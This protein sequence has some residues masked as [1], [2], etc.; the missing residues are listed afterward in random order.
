MESELFGH[1]RGAFTGAA[2]DRK[3]L[4]EEANGG[5]LFMDEI[6][7]LPVRHAVE[8]AEGLE[9]REVRPVGSNQTRKIDVR[10]I[11]ASSSSLRKLVAEK[12]FREDL[13]YRLNVYPIDV[14]S[15]EERVEDIPNLADHFLKKFPGSSKRRSGNS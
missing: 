11:S 6:N 7:N 4:M 14:P 1:I 8:A 5:T 3:G 9:D 12:R 10:I 15:L 2:T 13:Y